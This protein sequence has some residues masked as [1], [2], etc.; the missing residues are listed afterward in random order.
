MAGNSV[1]NIILPGT[2]SLST[3]EAFLRTS[4]DTAMEAL[5]LNCVSS[6]TLL[7]AQKHPDKY[8]IFFS[9]EGVRT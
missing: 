8:G 6:D 3:C 5:Q 9:L 2:T 4:A 7:D 1:V